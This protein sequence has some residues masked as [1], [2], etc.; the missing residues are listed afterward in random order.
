MSSKYPPLKVWLE[1]HEK[2]RLELEVTP[3]IKKPPKFLILAGWNLSTPMEKA[4]R[5]L[6]IERWLIE[7]QLEKLLPQLKNEDYEFA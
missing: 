3:E 2:V 1:L 7:N 6:E 5:W 4:A